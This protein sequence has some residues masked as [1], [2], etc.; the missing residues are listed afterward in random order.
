MAYEPKVGDEVVIR[1]IV[2]GTGSRFSAV[3]PQGALARR[4]EILNGHI[5]PAPDLGESEL[6]GQVTGPWAV[7]LSEA[8]E[9]IETRLDAL[10]TVP[11][12][13]IDIGERLDAL[14]ASAKVRDVPA[15]MVNLAHR[16]QTLEVASGT[17]IRVLLDVEA[18]LEE[19]I[20][21]LK[22]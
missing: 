9:K 3:R 7:A 13:A 4:V 12:W 1:A 16:V 17:R 5:A 15:T 2:I 11:S 10:E 19:I 18:K 21:Q 22:A 20:R 8:M 6:R 14:E